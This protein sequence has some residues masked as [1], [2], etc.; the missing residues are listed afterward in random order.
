M[1]QGRWGKAETDPRY[2]R[3]I[4]HFAILGG[5]S[6]SDEFLACTVRNPDAWTLK[7]VHGHARNIAGSE[8]G[9]LIEVCA[10]IT[11]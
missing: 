9:W 3:D 8:D 5:H 2:Q 10:S 4:L 7:G 6:V 11:P 1:G